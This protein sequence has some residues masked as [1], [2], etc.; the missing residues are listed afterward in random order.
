[1]YLRVVRLLEDLGKYIP[2]TG[3][4]TIE[5]MILPGD[6]ISRT[7]TFTPNAQYVLEDPTGCVNSGANL[8]PWIDKAESHVGAV[9][10]L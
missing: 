3:V 10:D 8:K 6:R 1:M 5:C 9:P 7:Q 2:V 4:P